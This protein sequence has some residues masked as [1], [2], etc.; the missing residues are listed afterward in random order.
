M[1]SI[2]LE[3][4][5][6]STGDVEVGSKTSPFAIAA[7][8]PMLAVSLSQRQ[9]SHWRPVR[10]HRKSQKSGLA[11]PRTI[12]SCKAIVGDGWQIW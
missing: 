4:L 11:S 10:L 9:S 6:T 3:L 2:E 12:P 1:S 5:L 7:N 8:P